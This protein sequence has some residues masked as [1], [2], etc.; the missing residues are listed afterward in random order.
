M[1]P[2]CVT[3]VELMKM[4]REAEANKPLVEDEDE[5]DEGSDEDDGATCPFC[6]TTE[7]C[8]HLL[9]MV[10]KTFAEA[11]GG[12][13]REAF[14]D[15]WF[16]RGE[17]ARDAEEGDFFQ[18]RLDEVDSLAD[19]ELTQHLKAVQGCPQPVGTTTAAL[20]SGVLVG[21]GFLDS[22]DC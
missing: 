10:D 20:L 14:N 12:V 3:F 21:R 9:L 6:D 8:D 19:V 16:N 5:S 2:H 18:K 1:A 11:Q 22:P 13:L 7:E 15:R 17:Q 4:R